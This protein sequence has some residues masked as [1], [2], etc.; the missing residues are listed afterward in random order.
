MKW[1][2]ISLMIA[3]D[4]N[5]WQ[6]C[7][8]ISMENKELNFTWLWGFL[9]KILIYCFIKTFCWKLQSSTRKFSDYKI[10][11]T[12]CNSAINSYRLQIELRFQFVFPFPYQKLLNRVQARIDENP[13]PSVRAISYRGLK[14][15]CIKPL[16]SSSF[17][18]VSNEGLY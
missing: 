8:N 2:L 11:S 15:K 1:C 6:W 5:Q 12:N 16:T 10:G 7:R 13:D 18:S 14:A 17:Y 3:A 4:E 9:N